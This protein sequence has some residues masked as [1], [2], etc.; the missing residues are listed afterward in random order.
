[1]EFLVPVSTN[2]VP[3]H[4]FVE[5]LTISSVLTRIR[6]LYIVLRRMGVN[7]ATYGTVADV[8]PTG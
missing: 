5:Y 7:F 2:T 6:M 8:R 4:I 3:N 1:M